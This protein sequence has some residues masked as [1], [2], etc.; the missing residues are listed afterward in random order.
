MADDSV[1]GWIAKSPASEGLREALT[2]APVGVLVIEALPLSP[3]LIVGWIGPAVGSCRCDGVNCCF[4]SDWL[5]L[6]PPT[7]RKRKLSNEIFTL[8]SCDSGV[9]EHRNI[10]LNKTAADASRMLK[11]FFVS[12][13]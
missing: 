5:R 3:D 2:P 6:L 7:K 8:C 9:K 13:V 1:A 12:K 11:D 4:R 10:K